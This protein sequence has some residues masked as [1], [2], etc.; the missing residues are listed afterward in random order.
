MSEK[1]DFF[2]ITIGVAIYIFWSFLIGYFIADLTPYAAI[3]AAIAAGIYTGYKSDPFTGT[4]NGVFTGA[5]GGIAGGFLSMYIPSIYGIPLSVP[6]ANFLVPVIQTV[7]VATSIFSIISL[8]TVGI[9]FGGLGGFLGSIKKLRGV[10]LLITL[11][12]LFIFYG[13]VDN[14][15][16]NIEKPGW[17]W[18]MSFS[19]VLTNR[20]DLLV[21][22]VFAIFVTILTYILGLFKEK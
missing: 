5:A 1:I 16:W 10:I 9:I 8:F 21:A 14:A 17:T 7:S 11:F 18:N 12:L 15:A 4:I 6:I 3:I 22:V 19:H 20:I 13:A 2:R